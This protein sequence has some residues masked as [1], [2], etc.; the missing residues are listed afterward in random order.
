M[1]ANKKLQNF[2]YFAAGAV[3]FCLLALTLAAR[4]DREHLSAQ[5]VQRFKCGDVTIRVKVDRE[6]D[7][8]KGCQMILGAMTEN[9]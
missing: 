5:G 2:L 3:L 7:N 9:P 4:I 6:Y 8:D 1:G